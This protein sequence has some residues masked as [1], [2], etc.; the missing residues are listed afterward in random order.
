MRDN[1][2]MGSAEISPSLAVPRQTNP[3]ADSDESFLESHGV[4]SHGKHASIFQGKL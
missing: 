1:L 2:D 3:T 4:R